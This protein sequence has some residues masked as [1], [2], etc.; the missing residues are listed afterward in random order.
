MATRAPSRRSRWLRR[1]RGLREQAGACR[2]DSG[3]R[4]GAAANATAPAFAAEAVRRA[5][6]AW[7]DAS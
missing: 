3:G 1:A 4:E 2:G 6:G 5:E 7:K